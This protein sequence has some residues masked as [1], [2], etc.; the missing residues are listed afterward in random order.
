[1]VCTRDPLWQ[2]HRVSWISEC[3]GVWAVSPGRAHQLVRQVWVQG[4]SLVFDRSLSFISNNVFEMKMA[5]V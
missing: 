3:L 5:L 2:L 1:M 4:S